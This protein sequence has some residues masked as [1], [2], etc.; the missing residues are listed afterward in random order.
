MQ[1]INPKVQISAMSGLVRAEAL[2]ETTGIGIQGF[3]AKPFTAEQLLNFVQT[4]F[5]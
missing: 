3:L 4:I 5:R 1:I 2:L